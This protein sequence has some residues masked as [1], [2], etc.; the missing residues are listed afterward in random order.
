M[1]EEVYIKGYD[2]SALLPRSSGQSRRLRV[3]VLQTSFHSY[4]MGRS[5]K[6]TKRPS[7]EQKAASKMA[8]DSRK[9]LSPPP[10]KKEVEEEPEGKAKKRQ[11]MR[12]KV[13]KVSLSSTSPYIY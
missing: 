9:P 6:F 2:D 12:A 10:A 8:R 1:Y 5:A 11:S 3:D 7:K 4:N 13:D